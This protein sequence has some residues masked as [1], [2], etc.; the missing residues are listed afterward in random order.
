VNPRIR[1]A[2]A[3][4]F[5]ALTAEVAPLHAASLDTKATCCPIVELRQYTLYPGNLDHFIDI[6]E[7]YF[8]ESQEAEGITVV[9]S[10]RVLDDPNRFLWIRGFSSMNARREALHNFYTG[11]AWAQHKADVRGMFAEADNVLLLHPAGA[12]ADLGIVPSPRPPIG[13]SIVPQGLLVATIYS[14]GESGGTEFGRFFETS[15]RPV[16]TDA[17]ARIVAALATEHSSNT[18]PALRI[19]D[20]ANVFV[21]LSCFPNEAAYERYQSTLAVDPRW[22]AIREQFALRRMYSPPELWRLSATPRS[23]LHC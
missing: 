17:G 22:V 4:L 13:S 10:F 9:G 12:S 1:H 19:R 15:I 14:L 16:L 20:D 5:A 6:F 3:L 7:R 18:Y 21:W 11:P 2:F 8:V 23:A